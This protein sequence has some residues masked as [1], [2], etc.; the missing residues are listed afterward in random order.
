MEKYFQGFGKVTHEF[1]ML[2]LSN[3]FNEEELREFDRRVQAAAGHEFPI[4]VNSK[5][6]DLRFRLDMSMGNLSKARRGEMAR[7]GKISRQA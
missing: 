6:M 4:F 1:P 3:A 2:S 5:L 7:S